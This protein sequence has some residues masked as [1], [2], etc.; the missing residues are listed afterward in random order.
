[1]YMYPYL[2]ECMFVHVCKCVCVWQHASAWLKPTEFHASH[3]LSLF[4]DMS[5]NVPVLMEP[6]M[7]SSKQGPCPM[8]LFLLFTGWCSIFLQA[9][10]NA[11]RLQNKSNQQKN[12]FEQQMR[13]RKQTNKQDRQTDN[14]RQD[15]TRQT[16]QQIK[17]KK[18]ETETDI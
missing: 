12:Y 9:C 7:L 5:L 17:V 1:M 3:F 14:T 6:I 16:A 18:N 8:R 10:Q 15:K 11:C 13:A 4:T 2:R